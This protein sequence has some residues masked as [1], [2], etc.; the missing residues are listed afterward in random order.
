MEK[1][2]IPLGCVAEV[3]IDVKEEKF[4]EN[5]I[6][7]SDLLIL[8]KLIELK[9]KNNGFAICF[10]K[11]L[12]D[13]HFSVG[14]PIVMKKDDFV[15]ESEIK[16]ESV[17]KVVYDKEYIYYCLLWIMYNKIYSSINHN[18][19]TCTAKTTGECL[20]RWQTIV[21]DGVAVFFLSAMIIY[22]KM[23]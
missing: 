8:T 12:S 5:F 21:I 4:N 20:N 2:V 23:S 15:W 13:C 9:L 22:L 16:D 19:L 6:N 3:A 10:N 11:Y 18:C 14:L 1:E 7:T 17:K